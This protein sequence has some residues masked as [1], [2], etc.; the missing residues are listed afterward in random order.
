VGRVLVS[1]SEAR[2]LVSR[3][4]H[5]PNGKSKIGVIRGKK[6]VIIFVY[7]L[8]LKIIYVII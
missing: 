1:P 2:A 3:Q 8:E 6:W 4:A 7:H 5:A